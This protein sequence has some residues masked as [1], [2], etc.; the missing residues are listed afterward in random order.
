MRSRKLA[1]AKALPLLAAFAAVLG[2]CSTITGLPIAGR[3]LVLS[4]G[5]AW[6][7]TVV[8]GYGIVGGWRAAA[9]ATLLAVMAFFVLAGP[10]LWHERGVERGEGSPEE[11]PGYVAFRFSSS[12]TYEKEGPGKI[13]QVWVALP[14]PHIDF[15]PIDLTSFYWGPN[16]TLRDVKTEELNARLFNLGT[17]GISL[18]IRI[19]IA[20]LSPG[21][22]IIVEGCF[23]VP[24]ENAEKVSFVDNMDIVHQYRPDAPP[25]TMAVIEFQS[26][27]PI[28]T[29]FVSQLERWDGAKWVTVEKWA[30]KLPNTLVGGVRLFESINA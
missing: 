18:R 6:L 4:L 13:T 25:Q 20:E 22:G 5:A 12:F 2:F 3:Q 29:Y 10:Q 28:P 19:D 30:R 15:V 16:A 26:E 9:A 1:V 24:S 27:L 17:A 7:A 8:V 23:Y 14:Y 21:E 11:R